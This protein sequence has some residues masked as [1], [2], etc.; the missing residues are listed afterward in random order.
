MEVFDR[1]LISGCSPRVMFVFTL[2]FVTT[3]DIGVVG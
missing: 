2:V 1:V 3:F